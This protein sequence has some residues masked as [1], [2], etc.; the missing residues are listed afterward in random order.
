MGTV[1]YLAPHC[2]GTVLK[3]VLFP[4]STLM[5]TE[6][7]VPFLCQFSHRGTVRG[8]EWNL[9]EQNWTDLNWVE[10]MELNWTDSLGF[11]QIQLYFCSTLKF[12][13]GT[14]LYLAPHS[15]VQQ[16]RLRLRTGHG[17]GHSLQEER[18]ESK[19]INIRQYLNFKI[20]RVV[21]RSTSVKVRIALRNPQTK[22]FRAEWRGL[23]VDGIWH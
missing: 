14:V 6:G 23:E 1:P 10:Q 4:F 3:Q 17:D 21:L 8:T 15:I 13:M 11:Y 9:T 19:V 16:F 22:R 7:T 18:R 12:S 20:V 5:L 2:M